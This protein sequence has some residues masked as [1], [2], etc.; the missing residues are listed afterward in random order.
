MTFHRGGISWTSHMVRRCIFTFIL[1]L[2]GLAYTLAAPGPQVSWTVPVIFVGLIGFLSNLAI[3]ECIGLMMETFDTCDLQP[4]ANVRHREQSL[5]A[6]VRKARTHYSSFPRVCAGFFVAQSLGFLLAA[7]A[8]GVSGTV[9]RALGAQLSCAGVAGIL[10][11]L[12]ILLLIVLLRWHSVQVVPDTL[13]STMQHGNAWAE[14]SSKEMEWKPIVLGNPSG[15]LR[16]M[17]VLELGR[18]SR[19]SEIR[20]LNGLEK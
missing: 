18:M 14:M 11:I 1:P 19:W 17:N 9:T 15:K 3:T 2:A 10:L 6:N 7:G 13:F 12:T 5:P 16:R 20:R 8:T 4:G